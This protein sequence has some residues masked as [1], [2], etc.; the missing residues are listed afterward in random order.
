MKFQIDLF[1]VAQ[2]VGCEDMLYLVDVLHNP[3]EHALVHGLAQRLDGGRDLSH[4]RSREWEQQNN[5]MRISFHNTHKKTK[6]HTYIILSLSCIYTQAQ[7]H[8]TYTAY[9]RNVLALDQLLAAGLGADRQ[10]RVAELLWGHT[11][12]LAG[13]A[14]IWRGGGLCDDEMHADYNYVFKNQKK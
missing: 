6:L 7:T 14:D 9:L 13:K 5:T 10:E 1:I 12:H 11:E 8:I 3:D 2:C 4:E